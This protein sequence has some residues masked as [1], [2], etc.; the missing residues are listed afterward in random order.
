MVF[1]SLTDNMQLTAI[2]AGK[3]LLQNQF[4]SPKKMRFQTQKQKLF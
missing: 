4:L 3:S 1:T 2:F